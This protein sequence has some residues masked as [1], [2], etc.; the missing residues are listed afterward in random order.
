[1]DA[2]ILV[3]PQH[4][5]GNWKKVLDDAQFHFNG[6]SSVDLKDRFGPLR[7]L[8]FYVTLPEILI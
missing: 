5:V 7:Y 3:S 6:R 4:G 8:S 2:N 1:M